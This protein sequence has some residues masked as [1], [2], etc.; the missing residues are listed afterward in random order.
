MVRPAGSP[1][2]WLLALAGAF[3]LAVSGA[4][5]AQVEQHTVLVAKPR[6]VDP[7]FRETVVVVANAPN[8]AT[9][10]VIINRPTAKSLAQILPGNAMLEKFTEPLFFGGP[11]ER[12]GVYAIFRAAEP[13]GEA[14]HVAGDLWLAL[15]PA[16]VEQLMIDELG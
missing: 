9:V 8:G 16:T 12:V 14:L 13:P 7:N 1:A 6:L 10:G 3:A 2:T 11:V 5:L 15:N 4:V